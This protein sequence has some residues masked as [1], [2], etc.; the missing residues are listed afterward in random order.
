VATVTVTRTLAAPPDA[1]RAAM[2]DLEAFVAA[3]GFDRVDAAA[4]GVTVC[5]DVGPATLELVLGVDADA[6]AALALDAREGPFE[7][8]RTEYRVAPANGGST[9]EAHTEFELAAPLVGEVLDATVVR[10]R[11][12]A[13]LGSQL[14]WLERT[15]D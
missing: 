11:R 8:M 7:R 9:V 12:R 2:A 14:D 3:S 4:D 6:D 1:V 13:E 10:R 15:A 5:H